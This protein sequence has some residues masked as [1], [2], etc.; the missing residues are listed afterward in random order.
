M[1]TRP[2]PVAAPTVAAPKVAY[3]AMV[4]ERRLVLT[5]DRQSMGGDQCRSQE[6][7]AMKEPRQCIKCG[8]WFYDSIFYPEGRAGRAA[9]GVETS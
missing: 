3:G 4:G 2:R 9:L 8:C 7:R 6:V 5:V 1:A